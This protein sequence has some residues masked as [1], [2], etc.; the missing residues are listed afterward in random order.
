[1]SARNDNATRPTSVDPNDFVAAVEHP[2]RRADAQTL[3]VM[4]REVTGEEPVMWGPTMLGWGSYHYRYASGREGD[5]LR[6]GFAPRKASLS[7]YGLQDA[8][9]APEVLDRLGKHKRAVG[10]VYVNKLADVDLEVLRESI[11]LAW[12]AP[13]GTDPR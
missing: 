12:H 6:I 5:W 3:L 13:R 8:K 4:M 7:L 9:G 10:C 11:A 1:V 2:T